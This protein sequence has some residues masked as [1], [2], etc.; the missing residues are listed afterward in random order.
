MRN[1]YIVLLISALTIAS[2]SLHAQAAKSKSTPHLPASFDLGSAM[3]T[4]F[5][6]FD[7]KT[8]SS[9]SSIPQNTVFDLK[10]SGFKIGDEIVVQ[11]LWASTVVENGKHKVVFLTYSV[12]KSRYGHGAT[13]LNNFECHACAPL[14][15]AAIFVR[16]GDRW[17]VES[18]RAVVSRGGGW[19]DPPSDFRIIAIGPHRIGIEISDGDTG[20]G[21]TTTVK[22]IVV[23]WKGKV[24][25]ALRYET[26][27][28]NKGD[29]GIEKDELPCYSNRKRLSFIP[30]ANHDYFDILL[31]LSGTDMTEVEPYRAKVV[32]GLERLTFEDGYYRTKERVD[33]R[34]SV[35]QFIEFRP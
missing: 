27:N 1:R 4:L 10:G 15:G 8:E 22:T 3:S 9:Q 11:P 21:E 7:P 2:L 18:S 29:C 14:I 32:R 31:T 5:D 23:P 13:D 19:G 33:D 26:T 16:I 34:T 12:P 28:D 35:E 17:Q 6:N 24:N 20:G 30:K 25:E